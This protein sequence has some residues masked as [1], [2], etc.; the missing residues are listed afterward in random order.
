MR[1]ALVPTIE[2]AVADAA[3][4]ASRPLGGRT[5]AWPPL[6]PFRTGLRCV[7]RLWLLVQPAYPVGGYPARRSR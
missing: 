5:T 7:T 3:S 4:C 2:Q 6:L 1:G